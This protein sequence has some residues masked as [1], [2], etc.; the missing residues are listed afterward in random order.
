MHDAADQLASD[1]SV[2]PPAAKKG[3]GTKPGPAGPER[4][5]SVSLAG[6]SITTG[7]Q[8]SA[9]QRAFDHYA[10]MA[11]V[12]EMTSVFNVVLNFIISIMYL[13]VGA[14]ALLQSAIGQGTTRFYMGLATALVIIPL[15]VINMYAR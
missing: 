15:L 12:V 8:M 13:F 10:G 1:D 2:A 11:L 5:V 3:P 4:K 6:L 14:P 9:A 7:P